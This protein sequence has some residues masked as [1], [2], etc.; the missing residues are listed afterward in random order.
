MAST[1][2]CRRAE[3]AVS[4]AWPAHRPVGGCTCVAARVAGTWAVATTRR[5]STQRRT[6]RRQGTPCCKASSRVKTGSTTTAQTSS[7]KDPPLPRPIVIHPTSPSPGRL[8]RCRET[9]SA[10][11]TKGDHRLPFG[12]RPADRLAPRRGGRAPRERGPRKAGAR[13]R[14]VVG[15]H[16]GSINR[17][18][19]YRVRV[20]AATARAARWSLAAVP[21]RPSGPRG[22]DRCARLRQS[23]TALG[24]DHLAALGE[25]GQRR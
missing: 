14:H 19:S 11:S 4:S 18:S 20:E 8:A 10:T 12:A 1:R 17:G 13:R 25:L 15:E 9:G 3:P 16:V 22:T 5:A 2:A 21:A 6:A 24:L 7:S 23:V